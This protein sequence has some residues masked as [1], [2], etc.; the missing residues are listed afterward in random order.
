MNQ[1]HW[2]HSRSCPTLPTLLPSLDVIESNSKHKKRGSPAQRTLRVLS[3][4]A[5]AKMISVMDTTTVREILQQFDKDGGP[6]RAASL[7][8]GVT[9]LEPHMT[10]SEAG[11]ED[12]DEVSIVF[13]EPN[14]VEMPHWTGKDMGQK[15]HVRIPPRTTSIDERAFYDCKALVKVVIPNSVSSIGAFA[16][17]CCTSLRQVEIPNSVT[18][19][20][21]A[22]FYGCDSLAQVRIPD[23]LTTI[24]YRT[25]A[26]CS[27]L[28]QVAIPNSVT[29]IE[30]GAFLGCSL[31]IQREIEMRSGEIRLR[32]RRF[33]AR[34]KKEVVRTVGSCKS[35]SLCERLSTK[36]FLFFT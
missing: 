10:M 30:E 13:Y 16:F 26:D 17:A 25:F 4:N 11:L 32:N 8:R 6:D 18:H 7:I 33:E 34:Q 3:A 20:G 29:S 5:D 23:F 9:L 19:I 28:T 2:V 27:S 1:L 31:R 21:E 12:R 15:L 22:A 35:S 14:L 24:K 36:E